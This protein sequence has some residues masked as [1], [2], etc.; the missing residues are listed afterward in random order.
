MK[1]LHIWNTAGVPSLIAETMD[2]CYNTKSMV[3]SRRK[4]TP[5]HET[6]GL[7]VPGG[8]KRFQI[9]VIYHIL[10]DYD[11]F[12]VHTDQLVPIIK[13]LRRKPVIL[14]Y[15]GSR[16]RGKWEERR[17]IWEKADKILVATEDLLE[18]APLE[19][20]HIPNPVNLLQLAPYKKIP[21]KKGVALYT[22]VAKGTAKDLA[23]NLAD[24]HN[25]IINHHSR[26]KQPLAHE[27]YLRYIAK[28]EYFIDVRRRYDNPEL[29]FKVPSQGALEA[30]AMGTK[31]IDHSGSILEGLPEVHDPE[32]VTSALYALYQGLLK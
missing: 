10:K 5:F 8:F 21:K 27:N 22:D 18:G 23:Q 31:V 12:H 2:R 24:K 3:L 16:I 14:H 15:H 30:L 19:A 26:D 17:K 32:S 1:I 13:K 29:V 11:V 6:Y 7:A 20:V 9:H 28:H 25:I 4:F